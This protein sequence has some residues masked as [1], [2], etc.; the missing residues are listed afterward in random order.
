M[1]KSVTMTL[2]ELTNASHGPDVRQ[3]ALEALAKHRGELVTNVFKR[4]IRDDDIEVR[5]SVVKIA[6]LASE[7]VQTVVSLL[8]INDEDDGVREIADDVF[9]SLPDLPDKDF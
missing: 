2:V 9:F 6:R 5:K 4:L 3:H 8:A 7:Q 1:G